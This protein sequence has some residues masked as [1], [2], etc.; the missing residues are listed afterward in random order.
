MNDDDRG[1][2][3][4]WC[5]ARD[6]EV[7]ETAVASRQSVGAVPVKG[8]QFSMPALAKDAPVRLVKFGAELTEREVIAD[9]RRQLREA[10]RRIEELEGK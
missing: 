5:P 10:R 9:L 3:R 8:L 1:K 7:M 2:R 4:K 6:V